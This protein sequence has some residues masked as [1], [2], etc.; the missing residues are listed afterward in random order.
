MLGI[1]LTTTTAYHPQSDG[2]TEQVNQEQEQYLW[3]FVNE[4]QD[5][6]ANGRIPVQQPCLFQ[7][8]TNPFS[9]GHGLAPPYGF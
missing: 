8:L 5:A 6:P 9:S 2:Q 7:H 3:V 4:R 1:A